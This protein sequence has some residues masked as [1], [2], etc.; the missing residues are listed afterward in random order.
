MDPKTEFAE[1][2]ANTDCYDLVAIWLISSHNENV[3]CMICG[4][5]ACYEMKLGPT[6]LGIVT[7]KFSST[8]AFL[9]INFQA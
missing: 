2:S 9:S 6:V 8:S 5:T 7:A 4:G 3:D 1:G